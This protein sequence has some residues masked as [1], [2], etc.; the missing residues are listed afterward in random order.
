MKKRSHSDQGSQDA[1]I[2]LNIYTSN[3]DT[4]NFIQQIILGMKPQININ[5]V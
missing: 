4:P 1:I 5:T 2:N 3:S